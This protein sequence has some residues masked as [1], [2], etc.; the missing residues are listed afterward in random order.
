MRY[1]TTTKLVSIALAV[2]GAHAISTEGREL[3][4]PD[5]RYGS[6]ILSMFR[7]HRSHSMIL[8]PYT[9][10]MIAVIPD[11]FLYQV[12]RYSAEGPTLLEWTP[13]VRVCVGVGSWSTEKIEL[14][15]E[16]RL[17]AVCLEA[18]ST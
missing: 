5:A 17:T 12:T 18:T 15:D 10:Y 3:A 13:T 2:L 4:V 6:M 11:A 9:Q 7:V 1:L 14:S 16:F 8:Y